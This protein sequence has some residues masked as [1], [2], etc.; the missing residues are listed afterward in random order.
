MLP[1]RLP[2]TEKCYAIKAR[3]LCSQAA[4]A[5]GYTSPNTVPITTVV[6]YV[7]SRKPAY[8]RNTWKQYKN[9]LRFHAQQRG[10][11]EFCVNGVSLLLRHPILELDSKPV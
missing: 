10:C 8:S 9:A 4:R 1:N 11:P 7:I 2:K 3:G 5:R 6:E